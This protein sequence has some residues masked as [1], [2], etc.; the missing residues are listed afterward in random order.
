MAG[1]CSGMCHLMIYTPD[2]WYRNGGMMVK[3]IQSMVLNLGDKQIGRKQTQ[4]GRYINRLTSPC[5]PLLFLSSSIL[6]TSLF[7]HSHILR[8]FPKDQILPDPIFLPASSLRERLPPVK[9]F[10]VSPFELLSKQFESVSRKDAG[11]QS[12]WTLTPA[13]PSP[14]VSSRRRTGVTLSLKLLRP[15]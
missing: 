6:R 2:S 8:I 13:S 9:S 12:I 1:M 10:L 15:E 11:H 3:R 7:F 4:R 5:P 14:S